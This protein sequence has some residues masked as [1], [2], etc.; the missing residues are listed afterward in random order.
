MRTLAKK[1]DKLAQQLD[2]NFEHA[3]MDLMFL[4]PGG[5]FVSKLNSF[6]DFPEVHPD[7]SHPRILP[8][9]GH[10][11]QQSNADVFL[12]HVKAHFGGD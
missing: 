7:V 8:K 9:C 10:K 5:R 12:E 11:R 3:I 1:G 2:G 4:S 6:H